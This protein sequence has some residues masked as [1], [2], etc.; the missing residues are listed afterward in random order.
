MET[1]MQSIPNELARRARLARLAA[2]RGVTLVEVLI[3]VTILAL[4]AGGAVLVAFP[5]LR[6]ARVK[7]A[8]TSAGAVR[9]AAQLYIEVDKAGSVDTC[10]TVQELIDSKKLERGKTQDPWDQ[11][12]KIIC[13]DGEVHVLSFGADH[14]EG[15]PDD[16]RDDTP[17][18]E[19]PRIANGGK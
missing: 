3:V 5:Q 19:V 17:L 12:F 1:N 6:E 15:T 4:I 11:P 7:T 10:P 9:Q 13:A 16:V 18:K 8:I 14:K 2:A